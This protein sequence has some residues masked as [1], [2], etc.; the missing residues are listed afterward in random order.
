MTGYPDVL[1]AVAGA[2]LRG[3]P[4]NGELTSRGAAFV[5]VT[6]TTPVYRMFVLDTDPPKPGVV[7][8][9]GE[10]TALEVEVWRLTAEAFGNFVAA[11]P[12]P[13]AIGRVELAG[14][15][16]VSG[17]LVEPVALESAR[18]I[19]SFGGW[20]DYLAAATTGP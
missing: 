13:M 9:A 15:T 16:T 14:G 10:G 20:K 17:F 2:H 11:L 12:P 7:R 5:E 8:T 1:L 6:R 4:L 19:S 18:D 3:Q